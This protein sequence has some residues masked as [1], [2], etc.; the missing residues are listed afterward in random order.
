L[1]D[2]AKQKVERLEREIAERDQL[3]EKLVRVILFSNFVFCFKL[4]FFLSRKL[5]STS[6][7]H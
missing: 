3:I 7:H 1:Y 2:E 4:S 5:R 6:N